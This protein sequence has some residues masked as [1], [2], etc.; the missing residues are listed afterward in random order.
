MQKSTDNWKAIPFSLIWIGHLATGAIIGIG[1]A[2]LVFVQCWILLLPI[3]IGKV[4]LSTA[5]AICVSE[6]LLSVIDSVYSN[7]KKHPDPGGFV[8]TL[9]LSTVYVLCFPAISYIV[10]N[11]LKTSFV[12]FSASL[13]ITVVTVLLSKPWNTGK[14]KQEVHEAWTKTRELMENSWK[15]NTE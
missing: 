10:T 9:S 15:D 4:L 11:D 6:T 5:L 14:T 3:K 13:L 2:V 12:F 8:P 1:I 7:A